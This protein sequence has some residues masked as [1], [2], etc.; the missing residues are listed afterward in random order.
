MCQQRI[1]LAVGS[2]SEGVGSGNGSGIVVVARTGGVVDDTIAPPS[3]ACAEE[4]H[5]TL[6]R[7]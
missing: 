7:F 1:V 4:S 5:C 3:F 2:G 6:L